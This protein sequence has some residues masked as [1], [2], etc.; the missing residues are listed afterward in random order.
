MIQIDE[1]SSVVVSASLRARKT[2]PKDEAD[3]DSK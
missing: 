1:S 2:D 3:F